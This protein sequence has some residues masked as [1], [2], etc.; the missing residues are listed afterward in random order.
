MPRREHCE[1][2]RR[3]RQRAR[4]SPEGKRMMVSFRNFQRIHLVGIGGIG[5]ERDCRSAPDAGLFRV[6][7]RTPNL[8]PSPN[9][10]RILAPPSTKVTRLPMLM[11][12]HVV[13][14]FFRSEGRQP[15]SPRSAQAENSGDSASGDACGTDA[16][17]IRHRRS[18]ERTARRLRPSIV[19]SVFGPPRILTPHLSSAGKSI[20]LARPRGLAKANI[21]WWR[22]TRATAAF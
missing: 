4:K 10:S 9:V 6:L 7:A 14:D 19:A 16:L 22:P 15:R 5:N 8:P 13:C 18:P 3:G 17:E 1:P 12:R 21:L 11:A 2:H 20:R